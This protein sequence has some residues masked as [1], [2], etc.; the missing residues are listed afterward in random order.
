MAAALRRHDPQA[1]VEAAH[2]QPNYRPLAA[3]ALDYALTGVTSIEE[4]F[5]IS[6]SLGDLEG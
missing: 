5:R 1:F 4:V 2:A 6:A 3:V